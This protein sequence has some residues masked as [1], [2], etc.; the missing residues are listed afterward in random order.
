MKKQNNYKHKYLFNIRWSDEDQCFFGEFPELTGCATH[1]DTVEEVTQN[2]NDAVETWLKAAKK[3][4]VPIPKPIAIKKWSGTFTT[5]IDPEIHRK[6]AIK[7]KQKGKTLSKFI[8][9]VLV[10]SSLNNA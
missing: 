3:A 8:N 6:L 10:R 7:A 9:E 2:A 1:G 4:R 5:R